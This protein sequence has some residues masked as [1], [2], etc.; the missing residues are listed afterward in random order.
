MLYAFPSRNLGTSKK[1]RFIG[2][3]TKLKIETYKNQY[4]SVLKSSF[5][6]EFS[7]GDVDRI[8]ILINEL[9][10][11]ITGMD[12]L[13]NGHK[14]RLLKRLEKL[15][16]ELHKRLSNLDRFWGIVGDAGV[17]LGRLGKDAKPIVDRIKEI[18]E[19]VWRTQARSEELPSNSPYPLLN[20]EQNT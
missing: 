12:N 19:I 6:Y 5:A 20:D 14:E 16:S 11:H 17:A 2:E 3:A 4:K 8:Q 13:S 7:Q 10:E 15:Q 1:N 18:S 9:R